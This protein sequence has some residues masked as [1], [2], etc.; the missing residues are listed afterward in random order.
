MA[1]RR[2][3]STVPVAAAW[4]IIFLHAVI[5]HNHHYDLRLSCSDVLHCHHESK[6]DHHSA[7]A[8]VESTGETHHHTIC[9]Y[10]TGPF[11]TADNTTPLPP[12]ANYELVYNAGAGSCIITFYSDPQPED[13]PYKILFRR[14]P[15]L[16]PVG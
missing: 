1:V 6:A 14:G 3:I 9:H 8:L 10:E 12:Q 16:A 4:L 5:P 11:H 13:S 7:G 2:E 15:P